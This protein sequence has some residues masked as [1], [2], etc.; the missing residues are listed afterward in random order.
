MA[1]GRNGVY[2]SRDARCP[3]VVDAGRGAR[4]R[5]A[6]RSE[7]RALVALVVG[8][9][10]VDGGIRAVYPFLPVIADALQVSFATL[11]LVVAARNLTGLAGPLLAPVVTPR[12]IRMLLLAGL[13]LTGG[14]A[15]VVLAVPAVPAGVRV[16]VLLVGFA[17]TGFARPLFALP[18]QAWVAA[19]VPVARR[20]RAVGVTELGWA[21]SLA[22]TVPVAGWL[23]PHWGWSAPFWL[24]VVLAGVGATAVVLGVPRDAS[25]VPVPLAGLQG[26]TGSTAARRRTSW[27]PGGAAVCA[28]AVLAVAAG[29]LLLVV[30]APWLETFG[31]SVPG[32]ALSALLIVA[33]ELAG[34]LAA[35]AVADRIGL[36]RTVFLALAVSAAVY[37]VLGGVGH[38]GPAALAI[39]VWFVAFEVTVVVLVALASAL[40][41]GGRE[42]ARLLG[43]LMAA[44]AVGNGL[45][46]ALAPV[47][48]A[49]G[50][51]AVAG[52]AS[53]V[54]ALAAGVVLFAGSR[55]GTLPTP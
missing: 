27:I 9:V 20:G 38:V 36:C 11:A 53:A 45:G 25:R 12:R 17:G 1:A 42:R 50:G 10:G 31:L 55:R 28:M 34:E 29:E 2:A 46:A 8:R 52:T 26:P 39:V 22:A 30:Y 41:A 3:V 13:A 32:I 48:F 16:A 6:S 15:L 4:E 23:V 35:A 47:L 37:A 49:A 40:P 19:H 21:L 51:M 18:L 24:V 33:A 5:P 7:R 43:A 44:T 54:L 14:S